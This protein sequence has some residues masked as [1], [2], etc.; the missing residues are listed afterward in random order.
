M[1]VRRGD[2][3]RFEFRNAGAVVHEAFIGDQAAQDSNAMEMSGSGAVS[4]DDMGGM[5][6]GGDSEVLSVDPGK[7]GTLSYTFADSG[8]FIIGCH[9]PGHYEAGMTVTVTVT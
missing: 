8:T 4:T 1:Q 2:N 6:H 3:V 7:T 9:Q 5:A